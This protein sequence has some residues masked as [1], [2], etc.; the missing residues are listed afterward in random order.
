MN[1]NDMP[2]IDNFLD[3]ETASVEKNEKQAS[4]LLAEGEIDPRLKLLSHS[5]RITLHKCPRK[6]QLYRLKAKKVA[7]ESEEQQV[8]FAYGHAVGEGIQASLEGLSETEV[9]MRTFLAWST[10]ALYKN[11]YQKKSLYEAIFAVQRFI[12]LRESGY[13]SDYELVYY[14]DKPAVEL[15]FKINLPNGFA[16]RGFIDAILKHKHTGEILVLELKTTSM[17]PDA[18][19]YKNSGQALGYSIVL[20]I[21]FPALSSYSVLYLVYQTKAREY[22]EFPFE[23]TLLQ[24]ALWLQELI[25]DCST[26]NLY[27]QYSVYPLHGENCNDFFKPCE[28]F[29]LCT[30]STENLTAPLTED[31]LIELERREQEYTFVIDFE[32]LI[33][34]QIAKTQETL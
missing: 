5:S 28:Y 15:A 1:T 6:Y 24:R 23:K 34:N 18:I 27:E 30:L 21:L 33:D 11:D 20:D 9:L 17:Q 16:Y 3:S 13:L 31:D 32:E 12:H 22:T 8:T 29:G 4:I 2:A 14:E 25:I 26:I 10:D 19:H 7:I